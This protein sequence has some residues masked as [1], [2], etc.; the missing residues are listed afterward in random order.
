MIPRLPRNVS[1]ERLD[2]YAR[3]SIVPLCDSARERCSWSSCGVD[4]VAAAVLVG[5]SAD[6]LLTIFRVD[7][8]SRRDDANA[9]SG[10]ALVVAIG[11]SIVANGR[12]ILLLK[13]VFTGTNSSSDSSSVKISEIGYTK[14]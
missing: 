14:Q 6:C 12:F 3:Y 8:S 13:I 2:P 11:S 10:V 7:C 9:R 5:L 4:I 1:L